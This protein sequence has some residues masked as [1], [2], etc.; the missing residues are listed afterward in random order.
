MHPTPLSASTPTREV[1][2]PQRNVK[3]A[4]TVG[5]RCKERELCHLRSPTPLVLPFASPC[6]GGKG[7]KRTPL[8]TLPPS[9]NRV[10]TAWLPPPPPPLH[11]CAHRQIVPRD[12]DNRVI[13]S[14]G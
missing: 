7:E 6:H 1:E 5:V 4:T 14:L 10:S 13:C 12:L 2:T 3:E 11:V 9:A 8:A